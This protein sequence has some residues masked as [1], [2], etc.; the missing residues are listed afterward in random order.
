[1]KSKY[2]LYCSSLR[3]ANEAFNEE[4][5]PTI[6]CIDNQLTDVGIYQLA[7]ADALAL[8]DWCVEN[9]H[10]QLEHIDRPDEA[11][12]QLLAWEFIAARAGALTI[13]DFGHN[14]HQIAMNLRKCKMLNDLVSNRD[15]DTVAKM[16]AKAFPNAEHIRNASAHPA[17][18]MWNPHFQKVNSFDGPLEVN[19]RA[20]IA[21]DPVQTHF[22][23]IVD[24][25]VVVTIYGKAVSY[26]LTSQS[27]KKLDEIRV[28]LFSALQK[29]SEFSFDHLFKS[30]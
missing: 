14:I 7:F 9:R 18:L 15:L 26:D 1:M 25:T 5:R 11:H 10:S 29:A 23:G 21:G 6:R 30:T 19:G 20:I 4:Y 24:S 8:F 28:A 13:W 12:R 22:S 17:D 3:I 27:L 16:F 2:E